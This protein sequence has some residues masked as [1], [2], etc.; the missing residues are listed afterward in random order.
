MISIKVCGMTRQEDIISTVKLGVNA[1]GFILTK[2]PRQIS[3]DDAKRLTLNLPPFIARVAVVVNPDQNELDRI[4]KSRVFDY[5]QFHGDEDPGVIK[6]VP[7]KTIK[8][9]SVS[10]ARDLE[11]VEEYRDVDYI[12]F[13]TKAGKKKGG[14]GEVFNWELLRDISIKRPFILAGGLGPDNIISAI[15][16]IR[17]AGVDINSRVERSPGIKDPGLLKETI[18]KIRGMEQ[19]EKGIFW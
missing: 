2:S 4:I 14:T 19:D 3:L 12:L 10:E 11:K 8:A 15:N 1:L 17:P 16:V 9:I 5:I 13:D 6:K 18:L 7:L